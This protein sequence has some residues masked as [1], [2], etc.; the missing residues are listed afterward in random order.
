LLNERELSL[1]L[2]TIICNWD[3]FPV[4]ILYEKF[5][6]TKSLVMKTTIVAFLLGMV[7]LGSSSC[8]VG[9]RARAGH[10]DHDRDYV[11][12]PDNG[13]RTGLIAPAH[14][15]NSAETASAVEK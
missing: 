11:T 1:F 5:L 3:V 10:H 12:P 6:S 14:Q 4:G 9:V 13:T 2:I 8:Y 15:L 7:M